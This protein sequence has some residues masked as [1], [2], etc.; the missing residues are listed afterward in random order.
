MLLTNTL[1]PCDNVAVR[2]NPTDWPKRLSKQVGA[3]ITGTRKAQNISAV[4]LAARTGELGYPI[5]RVTIAKIESG[6]RAVTMPELI[7]LAAALNTVPLALFVPDA[8]TAATEILPG[9]EMT[10]IAAVG[11]FAGTTSDA[12]DGVTRDKAVTSRLDLTMK[13]A[14]V[15]EQLDKE[16]RNLFQVESGLEKLDMPDG[17]RDRQQQRLEDVRERVA[18][19]E[20]QHDSIIHKLALG[21]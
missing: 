10:G 21:Y 16:R 5:H 7:V 13:L 14:E 19:L 18:S 2:D 20:Q 15:D 8:A 11:W 3:A 12:P 6:D 17:L 1:C 4:K 9:I